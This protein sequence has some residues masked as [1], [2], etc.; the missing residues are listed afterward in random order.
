LQ[1]L[2]TTG[3]PVAVSVQVAVRSRTPARPTHGDLL[4]TK[5]PEI[6]ATPVFS[7]DGFDVAGMG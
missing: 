4:A 2:R 3:R 7:F 1:R 5:V 6:F